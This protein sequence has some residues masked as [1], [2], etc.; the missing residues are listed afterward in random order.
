M[1]NGKGQNPTAL[2]LDKVDQVIDLLRVQ[3]GLTPYGHLQG[4]IAGRET[5][6]EL[7]QD[8]NFL[9]EQ[10]L[11][12]SMPSA[13]SMTEAYRVSNIE[14]RIAINESMPLMRVEVT[15]DNIAQDCWISIRG[16]LR[17]TGRLIRV[18]DTIPFVLPM[19]ASMFAICNIPWISVRVSIGYDFH[20]L[21]K[22]LQ[23][24]ARG[25]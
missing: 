8:Q 5:P 7:A 24:R 23:L 17:T 12:A 19:G 3:A 1:P 21:L 13:P 14:T 20:P 2:L 16:V 15:N 9:V 25:K 11:A 4:E 10:L 6:Y 22:E 18:R